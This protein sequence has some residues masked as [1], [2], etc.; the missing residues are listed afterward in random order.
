LTRH[1]LKEQLQHDQF[2]DAVSRVVDYTTQ[3]KE[4]ATRIGVIACIALIV[5]GGL[6]WYLSYQSS[7]RQRGLQ[8]AFAVVDAQ[9]GPS[10]ELVKTFPTEQAKTQA[11]MKALSDLL[12][13]YPGT[14]EG[15]IAQY[16][17]GTL[18]AQQGDT[19][20]AEAD[21]SNV[22]D[23]SNDCKSLAKIALAQLYMGQGRT[24][25]AQRL[26]QSIIEKPSDLVSKAQAQIMLARLDQTVNP[27]AA[28]ALLQSLKSPTESPAIAR[29][30]NELEAQLS[31]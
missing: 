24:A 27:K 20:G 9:V 7:V 19:K 10:N 26:L 3:H 4:Q 28:K 21:L 2:T 15:L 14:R 16:Y 29:A 8:A 13:K 30:A 25:E 1:E 17:L 18:K 12:A 6:W 22:A 23:S 31:Q 5:A 11:S